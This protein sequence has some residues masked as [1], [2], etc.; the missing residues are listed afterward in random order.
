MVW[1]NGQMFLFIYFKQKFSTFSF[2]TDTPNDL[3]IKSKQK[4]FNVWKWQQIL[5][6]LHVKVL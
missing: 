6:H 3:K 4:S 1:E 2:P 5:K